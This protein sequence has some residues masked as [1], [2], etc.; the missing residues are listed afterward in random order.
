M[1]PTPIFVLSKVVCYKYTEEGSFDSKSEEVPLN[2]DALKKTIK[3]NS[4]V[5]KGKNFRKKNYDTSETVIQN[6]GEDVD[7]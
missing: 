3:C 1:S 4:H 5:N 7:A 2:K 6:E